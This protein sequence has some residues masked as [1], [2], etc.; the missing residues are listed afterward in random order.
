G[1]VREQ[2][3]QG[4]GN[5]RRGRPEED[6]EADRR[7][8]LPPA[9][10]QAPNLARRG[11]QQQG[12]G[13]V[14]DGDV[15]F[16]QPAQQPREERERRGA[17]GAGARPA[18]GAPAAIQSRIVSFSASVAAPVL[19]SAGGISSFSTSCHRRDSSGF[20]G[21]TSFGLSA[22]RRRSVT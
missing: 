1:N 14:D 2:P 5:H 19:A 20:D 6:R 17:R 15:E 18:T 4:R 13:K 9:P 8:R 12:D 3:A 16:S 7:P 10:Q 11:R 22:T 21:T